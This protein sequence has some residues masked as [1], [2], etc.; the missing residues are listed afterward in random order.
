MR[1]YGIGDNTGLVDLRELIK[2]IGG[3]IIVKIQHK[4]VNDVVIE[5]NFESNVKLEGLVQSLMN[6]GSYIDVFEE[7][8]G[9]TL[10]SG[11]IWGKHITEYKIIE[12]L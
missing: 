9:Y 7:L 10:R 1:I 12:I 8:D 3:Q 4:I 6:N 2:K 11:D 5:K